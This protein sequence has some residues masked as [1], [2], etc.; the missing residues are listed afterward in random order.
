MDKDYKNFE[1]IVN[2]HS[3]KITNEFKAFNVNIKKI[4][5]SNI[6]SLFIPTPNFTYSNYIYIYFIFK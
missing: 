4:K 6:S 2:V 1:K 5:G 3:D